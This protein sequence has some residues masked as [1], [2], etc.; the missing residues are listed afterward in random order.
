MSHISKAEQDAIDRIIRNTS[1]NN[2]NNN[3]PSSTA[4]SAG[5]NHYVTSRRTANPYVTASSSSTST[6]PNININGDEDGINNNRSASNAVAQIDR[7]SQ[8]NVAKLKKA[9]QYSN[10]SNVLA[11]DTSGQLAIQKETIERS[12]AT[13]EDTKNVLSMTKKT[14]RDMKLTAFK[15]KMIKFGIVGSLIFIIIMI[16]YFKFLKR[17]NE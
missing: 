17:K 15:E 6:D 3:Q 12:I 8:D 5:T 4:V 13:S 11:D 2:N 9:L 14:L 16:V 7:I 10:Q 1:N